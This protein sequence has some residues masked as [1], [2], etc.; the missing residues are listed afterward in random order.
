M[1][2]LRVGVTGAR[3]G[4]ELA[5]ALER[6]GAHVRLGP[7][8]DT[9][10]PADDTRL[11]AE[12]DAIL[13]ADTAWAA[14][15]TG[16]GVRAWAAAADAHGRGDALRALLARVPV[17]ARGPKAVGGLRTLGV[18]AVF[19]SPQETDA[20]VASWLCARLAPGDV[21]AVQAHGADTGAAYQE[22]AAAGARVLRATPYR[23]ALPADPEPAY[24]LVRTVVA[25]DVDAVVAT[26]QPAVDNL[27]TLAG[28]LDLAPA[29]VDRLRASVAAA[30]VGPVTAEAF[31]AHGMPVAVMP[32][33]F[34]TAD[35]IRALDAWHARRDASAVP[36]DGPRIELVPDTGVARV[37]L[38]AVPL[39]AREFAVLAAL[40]RRP[41]VVCRLEDLAREA[42]GH[43]APN[44]RAAVKH[45]VSRLR[46]KLG[47][48][49]AMLRCVRG[50]G[51]RYD[52]G[53]RPG[54]AVS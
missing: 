41:D 29:L 40:V 47:P 23:C 7:T 49:G 39:G 10:P 9:V 33:R 52:P 30:A 12:T 26:S 14:A 4:A 42:W 2:G 36:G 19:V 38:R 46:R 1:D 16:E 35:L 51:Y 17:A 22:L 53:V 32:M 15:S 5:A 20:D 34:R 13:A 37:G 43:A 3:K 11:I 27:V 28:H 50:V 18:D 45:H 31:E 8:L 24:R 48:A 25:G 6:R 21:V 54:C 44:D